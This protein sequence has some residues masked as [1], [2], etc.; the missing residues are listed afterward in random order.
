[1]WGSTAAAMLG[2]AHAMTERLEDAIPLLREAI[3]QLAESRRTMEALF[4]TY[5]CEAHLLARQLEEA[6]ALAERALAMS[7]ERFERATEA[8]ALYLLGEIAA[9]GAQDQASDRHY[10]GA[11][12]LA[13]ELGLRPLVGH[14]HLGLA[15]LSRRAGKRAESAE[16][17][18]VATSMYR[19]MGMTYWLEKAQALHVDTLPAKRLPG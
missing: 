18:A 3:A 19:E 14:C 6:V 8:R 15:T 5:L 4:T 9:H 16:H 7:R 13:G 1:M 10:H 2:Y 17:L 12:A 11:L